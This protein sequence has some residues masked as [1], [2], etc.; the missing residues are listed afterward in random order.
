MRAGGG[1]AASFRHDDGEERQL[2]ALAAMAAVEDLLGGHVPGDSIDVEHLAVLLSL[3]F[4][5]VRGAL[6]AGDGLFGANDEG[7]D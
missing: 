5:A 7:E 2:R 4:D 1:A 6:P 3:V